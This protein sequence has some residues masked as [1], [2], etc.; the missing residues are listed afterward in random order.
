MKQLLLF[1]ALTFLF[2][3]SHAQVTQI[4]ANKSLHGV[5]PLN[6]TLAIFESRIDESI[7][8]SDGTKD[9]TFQISDTIKYIGGGDLLNG[10]YIF[11][12]TSPNCGNELF[13]TDGTKGGTT[14]IKDIN[15]GIANSQPVGTILGAI[16][17]YIYFAAITPAEG[18]ELWRTD[19]TAGNTTLVKDIGLSAASGIDPSHFSLGQVGNTILFTA[20]TTTPPITG[21]EVWKTDGT[22]GNTSLLKDI[23]AGAPSS[24]A[25]FFYPFNNM[26][27]FTTKSSVG[28]TNE[29]WRTDGTQ[30]GTVLIKDNIAPSFLPF[31]F[32]HIFKNR[33]YFLIN[34]NVHPGNALYSTDGIDATIAHTAFLKDMGSSMFFVNAINL[35]DKF[36]FPYYNIDIV[37]GFTTINDLYQC[38]GTDKGTKIF[39]SF[40][41]NTDNPPFIYS[42]PNFN[43]LTKTITYPLFNGKFYFSA[44]DGIHGNE[45]W[46]SDGTTTSMLADINPDL[47]NG[48]GDNSFLFTSSY[49]F[50]AANDGVHGNELWKTNGTAAGTTMVQDIFAGIKNANPSLEF[51][52]NGKIFFTANDNYPPDGSVTDLYVVDGNFSPLPVNLL[53]FTVTTKDADA[54][55]QWSTAQELNSR[56][57]IIQSSDDAR[58]WNQIGTVAAAGNSSLQNNYSFIDAGVMNSGKNVV[59]YRLKETD[60]DGQ[61]TNS[62]IIYLKIKGNSQWNVQLYSNPVHDNNVKIMLT[63]VQGNAGLTI[64]DLNGRVIYKKQIQNQ[65][66]LIN[67]ATD[68][69]AGVYILHVTTGEGSKSIKFVKE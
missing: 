14:I 65:N 7:W 28:T 67:L 57:F 62:N 35:S 33:A 27:L 3:N 54:I 12:G 45:L 15:P 22:P 34:D 31:I 29:I 61:T 39:K 8:V 56:N 9:G 23:Y 49:L 68:I 11:K 64:N 21:N 51:V 20:S 42:S 63:G 48:I 16:N 38:D 53:N 50:F 17:G 18:C 24:N 6:N 13:I 52:N 1:S 44:D 41:P 4:N 46:M 55:L 43:I 19:G 60:L 37:T 40:S 25:S 32:F 10:K 36:I 59:Y 69:P 47:E 5:T 58:H 2:F 26:V 66:G 30:A